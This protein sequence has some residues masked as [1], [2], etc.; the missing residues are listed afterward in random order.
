M[1]LS[2]RKML[3]LSAIIE[4]LFDHLITIWQLDDI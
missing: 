1:N 3:D 2:L 4:Q